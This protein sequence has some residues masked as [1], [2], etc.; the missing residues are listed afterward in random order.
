M[1][2]FFHKELPKAGELGLWRIEEQEDFFFKQLDL[3]PIEQMQLAQIKGRLRLEWLAS[4]LLLHTMSGRKTRGA[5][6]KDEF[7]KP[8]LTG[9]DFEISISHSWNI[10]AVMAAPYLIGVDIQKIVPRI[11]RIAPKFMRPTE[12]ASLLDN[13]KIEHLHIYWC[14]KEALYKAHG[15][16]KLDF[17][18]HI[19]IE[20]FEYDLSVGRCRGHVHKD[21]YAVD[22]NI[23]YEKVE[24]F[25]LVYCM[26][27]FNNLK[28]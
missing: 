10:A 26:E 1:P 20:P 27:N 13:T 19:H 3:Y 15:R 14:A 16:K 11:E 22:F 9:S 12:K 17:I 4:R 7:G 2:K 28:H 21:S 6:L 25:F 5:C 24:D 8:H 23:N 18:E